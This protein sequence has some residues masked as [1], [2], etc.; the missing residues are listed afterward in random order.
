MNQCNRTAFD[1]AMNKLYCDFPC[2][3]SCNQIK[4]NY[5]PPLGTAGGREIVNPGGSVEYKNVKSNIC[6]IQNNNILNCNNEKGIEIGIKHRPPP[7]D[8]SDAKIVVNKNKNPRFFCPT[9]WNFTRNE[10]NWKYNCMACCRRTQN[11][12]G[13]SFNCDPINPLPDTCRVNAGNNNFPLVLVN[14]VA[15][16]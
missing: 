6:T 8:G 7:P 12:R 11:G 14:R 15:P 4:E 3:G 2:P 9:K 1:K 5:T 13:G 10:D 16:D